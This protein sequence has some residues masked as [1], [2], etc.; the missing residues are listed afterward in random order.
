MHSLRLFRALAEQPELFAQLIRMLYRRR[1]DGTEAESGEE[2]AEVSSTDEG[3]LEQRRTAAR[4]AN[5]VLT[6]WPTYPG[7]GTEPVERERV[8]L[9]WS[10]RARVSAGPDEV[11]P[12]QAARILIDELGPDFGDHLAMAK[13]NLRGMVTKE[14]YEGGRQE[15]EIAAGYRD[16]ASKLR[17]DPRW[18]A[19]AALLD[20]MVDR[21]EREAA[22]ADA[23]A[24]SEKVE[25]G[26]D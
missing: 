10:R 4:F 5:H 26:E 7:Q 6:K 19:A 12:C 21:Y 2:E 13:W 24:R 8:L 11:W 9:D 3:S 25:A 23:T 17:Q 22:E 20:K 15:R 1:V 14:L 18:S 16:A